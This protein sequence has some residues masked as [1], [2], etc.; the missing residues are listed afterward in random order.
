MLMGFSGKQESSYTHHKCETKENC[1]KLK[2]YSISPTTK[3]Q[4]G[5]NYRSYV[6]CASRISRKAPLRS[7]K[8]GHL[9][10][11]PRISRQELSPHAP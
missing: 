10:V 11:L 3:E 7:L 4:S 5:N 8:S 1:K 6:H 2:K 9:S